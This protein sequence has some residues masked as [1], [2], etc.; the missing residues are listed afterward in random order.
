[1]RLKREAMF[2]RVIAFADVILFIALL[3]EGI[4]NG[5]ANALSIMAI[6]MGFFNLLIGIGAE[7]RTKAI[8]WALWYYE[9]RHLIRR[10][11]EKHG[12]IKLEE[13]ETETH[14]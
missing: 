12:Q 1:M 2:Y 9:N 6:A 5:L 14:H 13:I 7:Q 10:Y 4:L 8:K 11:H 3:T